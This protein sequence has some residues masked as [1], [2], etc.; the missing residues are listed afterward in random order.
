M[1]P[2]PKKSTCVSCSSRVV[3]TTT[4]RDV[5]KTYH[6]RV[7]GKYTL[8]SFFFW[9][10]LKNCTTHLR[11]NYLTLI[12]GCFKCSHLRPQQ[13]CR[14][15]VCEHFRSKILRCMP[16]HIYPF[17]RQSVST[18]SIGAVRT[19]G[20]SFPIIFL[21]KSFLTIFYSFIVWDPLLD[22]KWQKWWS[23]EKHWWSECWLNHG[24][25]D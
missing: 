15:N 18:Y 21:W 14:K 23:G 20:F 22:F 6:Y 16:V 3:E 12:Y 13:A 8:K 10:Q 9:G 25:R 24:I 4:S 7:C 2:H 11:L 19:T 5:M 1:Q 17:F